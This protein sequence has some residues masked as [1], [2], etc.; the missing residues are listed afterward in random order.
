MCTL[1]SSWGHLNKGELIN[2]MDNILRPR[3]RL[4]ELSRKYPGIW[5][6]A[7]LARWSALQANKKWPSYCFM[8]ASGWIEALRKFYWDVS[9]EVYE[10]TDPRAS[11]SFSLLAK[12]GLTNDWA[13][14]SMLGTWRLTQG[15]YRFDQ[16]V[17]REVINTPSPV[18]YLAKFW[19]K[20]PNGAL[21]Y[22]L[23]PSPLAHNVCTAFGLRL[24][25]LQGNNGEC[26]ASYSTWRL[27]V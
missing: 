22:Q 27:A 1:G 4:N 24:N 23:R 18:T 25:G 10:G 6:T 7:D 8:P 5:K 9:P 21:I 11:D 19:R 14:L 20:C 13:I 2:A 3:E 26:C 17:Y 16:D 15:I 12:K